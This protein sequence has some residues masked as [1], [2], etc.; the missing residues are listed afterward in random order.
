MRKHTQFEHMALHKS[1]IPKP[2]RKNHPFNPKSVYL[3]G[4]QLSL[5]PLQAAGFKGLAR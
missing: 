2:F 5:E 1:Y 3:D 4:T